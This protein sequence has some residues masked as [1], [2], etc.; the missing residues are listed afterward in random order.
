M[1]NDTPTGAKSI[2]KVPNRKV[3][4]RPKCFPCFFLSSSFTS[5]SSSSYR[6]VQ[7]CMTLSPWFLHKTGT[8][9]TEQCTNPSLF[10]NFE[11]SRGGSNRSLMNYGF[12]SDVR[13]Y[14]NHL[15]IKQLLFKVVKLETQLCAWR[16]VESLASIVDSCSVWTEHGQWFFSQYCI[17]LPHLLRKPIRTDLLLCDRWQTSAQAC[18]C[19]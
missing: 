2:I 16:Q 19:C 3:A 4:R 7:N 6:L 1:T 5:S 10:H 14:T 18:I 15:T 13:M 17:H 12:I 9:Y 8:F 11:A